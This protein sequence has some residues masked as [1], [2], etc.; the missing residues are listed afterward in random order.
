MGTYFVL[1]EQITQL[2]DRLE[3]NGQLEELFRQAHEPKSKKD[4]DS[5][6]PYDIHESD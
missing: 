3:R 2:A 5:W 4:I 6:K 1:I